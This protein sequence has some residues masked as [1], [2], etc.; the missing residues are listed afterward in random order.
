MKTRG[1]PGLK[2]EPLRGIMRAKRMLAISLLCVGWTL[3][4]AAQMSKDRENECSGINLKHMGLLVG[5]IKES[6]P[7]GACALANW[8]K[9]RYE[10]I[11]RMYGAEPEDC[12]KTEIGKKLDQTIKVRIHQEANM[13]KRHCRRR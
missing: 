12:R 1:L 4:A 11:S 2:S 8:L 13:A 5:I 9:N 7:T 6:K 10:E 3:P